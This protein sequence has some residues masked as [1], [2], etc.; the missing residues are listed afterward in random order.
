MYLG[1]VKRCIDLWNIAEALADEKVMQNRTGQ[2]NM[3]PLLLGAD[4]AAA[5][6]GIGRSLFLKLDDTG[7][8]PPAIQLGEKRKLWRYEE[9]QAWVRAGCPHRDRWDYKR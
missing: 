5:V 4:D 3:S 9:L 1:Q 2:L 7:K 6:L 8:T